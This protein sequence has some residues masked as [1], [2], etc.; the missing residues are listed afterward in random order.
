MIVVSD[1]SPISNLIIIS[2]LDILK[3][4]FGQVILP[5]AV[6]SEILALKKLGQNIDEYLHADWINVVT[7]KNVELINSLKLKLDDGE[8]EAITLALETDC[9]WLLIDERAGTKI[10]RAEGLE[11][12]GLIGV[13]VLAKQRRIIEN[14]SSIITELKQK[15][16]WIDS[17][18]EREILEEVGEI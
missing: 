2:R 7:P 14:I 8:A 13:L 15:G 5:P 16:F 6:D 3:T 11:T 1:T 12:I 4:V 10:A 17:A 18:F 9:N